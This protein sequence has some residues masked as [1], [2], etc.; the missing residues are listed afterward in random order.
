MTTFD[1][2]ILGAYTKDTIVRPSG[3]TE[4]DGGGFNYA[5]LAAK[6]TG[7]EILAIT[8]LHPDDRG[9]AGPLRE[10][11]VEVVTLESSCSTHMRLEYPTANPDERI[12]S[13]TSVVDPFAPSDLDD[14]EARAVLVTA[15][16]RGEAP[17]ALLETVKAWGALLAIDVQG[18]VRIVGPDGGL[19]YDAAGWDERAAVLSLVDILKTDAV[20]AEALTGERDIHRAARALASEGPAEIVL[21]H[22]DGLLVHAGGRDYEAPFRPD[23]MRGRSGRGDTCIGSY[24]SKRLLAPPAEATRWAGAVTTLKLEREGPI[25]RSAAEVEAYLDRN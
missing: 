17:V 10:A 24:V 4:V 15:S 22:R 18:F 20:E 13:V 12:L 11:G 16:I 21:T 8:R 6:L 9:I 14:I 19:V 25:R 7:L 5:A 2:A 3:V 23:E 1:L